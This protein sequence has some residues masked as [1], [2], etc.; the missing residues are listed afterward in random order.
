MRK[1]NFQLLI[2][3]RYIE[4]RSFRRFVEACLEETVIVYVDHL[5]T[6]VLLSINHLLFFFMNQNCADFLLTALYLFD[7]ILTDILIAEKLH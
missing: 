7:L 4:E 6:Q 1:T 2:Y 3:S 5:L